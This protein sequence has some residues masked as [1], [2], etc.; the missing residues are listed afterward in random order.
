MSGWNWD[1]SWY[2]ITGIATV[3]CAIG[4]VGTLKLLVLEKS[5]NKERKERK[6]K[7]LNSFF[8]NKE[9]YSKNLETVYATNDSKDNT[10][11][12]YSLTFYEYEKIFY[13]GNDNSKINGTLIPAGFNLFKKISNKCIQLE[14][15]NDSSG[16]LTIIYIFKENNID[17]SKYNNIVK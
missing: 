5:V 4:T 17:I 9:K 3:A 13:N 15:I 7:R 10:Q 1:T 11:N 2:A 14:I 16:E 12:K 8:E 6:L